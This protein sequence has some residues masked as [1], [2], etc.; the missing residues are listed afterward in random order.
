MTQTCRHCLQPITNIDGVQIVT[1]TNTTA[2]GL[3][4]CPPNP[5]HEGPFGDHVPV[6]GS[7]VEPVKCTE[8]GGN[9]FRCPTPND[10]VLDAMRSQF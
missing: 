2:D 5:D 1:G 6:H 4:Y 3:S 8:C 10:C 7:G 9:A